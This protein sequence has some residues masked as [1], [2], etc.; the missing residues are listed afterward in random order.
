MSARD[1][2]RLGECA[3]GYT[4]LGVYT[5]KWE[6]EL[7]QVWRSFTRRI[8]NIHVARD[9]TTGWRNPDYSQEETVYGVMVQRDR[10]RPS[11]A[12]GVVV[13]GDAAFI[14]IDGLLSG[15]QL[16]DEVSQE[17][18]EVVSVR[19]ESDPSVGGF[20]FRVAQLHRLPFRK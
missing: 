16:W 18:W 17:L 11:F 14:C 6:R 1:P 15:D 4:R 3:L 13:L 2:C 7:S 10:L 19:P 8:A 5:D 20:A 12:A 9:S